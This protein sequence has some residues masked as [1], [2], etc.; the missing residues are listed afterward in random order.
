MAR[1]NGQLANALTILPMLKNGMLPGDGRVFQQHVHDTLLPAC[2]DRRLRKEFGRYKY[3][4]NVALQVVQKKT[5]ETAASAWYP[6]TSECEPGGCQAFTKTPTI[7]SALPYTHTRETRYI[8]VEWC[9]A[10]KCQQ[11]P[12]SAQTSNSFLGWEEKRVGET[13]Q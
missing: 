4:F 11:L 13:L 6:M 2:R 1:S 3:D 9:G 12:S 7:S 10:L 8:R 5:C